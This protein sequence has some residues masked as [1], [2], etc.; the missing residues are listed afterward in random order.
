[1]GE[2]AGEAWQSEHN[3]EHLSGDSEGFIDHTRVE[4]DVGVELARD[5]VLVFK[6]NTLKLHGD[7]N[8]G[9]ASNDRED[10]VGKPADKS[11][12]WVK[13]LVDSVTEAHEDL[14]AGLDV[15]DELRD[16]FN[17]TN[18]IEHAEH[19]LVGSTMTWT[20][21]GSDGT[22]E[23]GVHI[24]LRGGHVADSCCGAVKFMLGMENKKNVDS[25]DDL[26][27]GPEV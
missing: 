19:S 18:L 11:G 5:E 23:R 10:I 2:P 22:G 20:I 7:V 1:M 4:V 21:E 26:G 16:C 25:L 15:R 6:G 24:R 17:G 9:L 27:V 8:H 14:L 13:V 12:S 3:R